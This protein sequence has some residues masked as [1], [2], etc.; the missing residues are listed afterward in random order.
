MQLFPETHP[1][2]L[3]TVLTLCKNDFFCAVD[4]LLYAK[5]CKALYN[6]SQIMFKR[7]SSMRSHPYCNPNEQ[8]KNCTNTENNAFKNEVG[9]FESKTNEA[10]ETINN[11]AV[12][13][14]AEQQRYKELNDKCCPSNSISEVKG[15]NLTVN[16]TINQED[17][18]KES[19]GK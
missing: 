14:P 11:K 9:Q 2:T 13:E 5:R 6:R 18:M 4:K 19:G 8:C 15:L 16:S 17:S 1:A 12:G 7:C 3:H 10:V